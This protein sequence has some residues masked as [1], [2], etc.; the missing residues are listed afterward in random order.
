[1][2]KEMKLTYNF[3]RGS[4]FVKRKRYYIIEY[5]PVIKIQGR[6]LRCE[7]WWYNHRKTV[8]VLNA[9]STAPF[10]AELANLSI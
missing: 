4:N 5:T 10:E 6:N 1:M 9:D 7:L 3:T 2:L 8:G